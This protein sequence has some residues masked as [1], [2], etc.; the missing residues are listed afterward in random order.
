MRSLRVVE[1]EAELTLGVS[2]GPAG[3]FHAL[4]ELEHDDI[5][6]S[7]GLAGDRVLHCAG[8]SL[9]GGEGGEEKE[10]CDKDAHVA[11]MV[12]CASHSKRRGR[13]HRSCVRAKNALSQD[14]SVGSVQDLF[15]F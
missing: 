3:F 9:G 11:L 6:A 4:A 10:E 15:P 1:L 2:F 13:S 5:V 14:D 12:C 8:E 7:G